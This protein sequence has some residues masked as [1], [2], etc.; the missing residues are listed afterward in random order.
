MSATIVFKDVFIYRPC[1][2]A[3]I[4]V[5]HLEVVLHSNRGSQIG[6]FEQPLMV[7]SRHSTQIAVLCVN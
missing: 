7:V 4:P 2:M 3:D 6:Y 1:Q 5:W